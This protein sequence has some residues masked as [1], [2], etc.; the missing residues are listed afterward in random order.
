MTE[1]H[2]DLVGSAAFQGAADEGQVFLGITVEHPIMGDCRLASRGN[3]SS[4][5]MV[6]V[7]SN[8]FFDF[9]F[10]LFNVSFD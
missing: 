6:A 5:G 7:T 8:F 1:M 4:S 9:A 10:I 3:P 2:P